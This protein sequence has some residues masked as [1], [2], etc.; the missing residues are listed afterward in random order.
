M[1]QFF[2]HFQH[3]I[4]SSLSHIVIDKK[5]MNFSLAICINNLFIQ[6]CSHGTM[7][8]S[9]NRNFLFFLTIE[10]IISSSLTGNDM[11]M[12]ITIWTTCLTAW[13]NYFWIKWR[14]ILFMYVYVLWILFAFS[15]TQKKTIF[16]VF[17]VSFSVLL[18]KIFLFMPFYSLF[19]IICFVNIHVPLRMCMSYLFFCAFHVCCSNSFVYCNVSLI[20]SQC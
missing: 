14:R 1:I 8:I 13:R 17:L 20:S 10:W 18:E 12:R 7:I 2:F 3:S 6:F 5:K 19:F 15:R 9:P 11:R 4:S 16:S